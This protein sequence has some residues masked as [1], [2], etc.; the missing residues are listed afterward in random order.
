MQ[1][2]SAQGARQQE[3]G[4]IDPALRDLGSGLDGSSLANG[5]PNSPSQTRGSQQVS[6]A[7]TAPMA[8]MSTTLP[9][10]QPAVFLD[11]QLS[12][13][14][15]QPSKQTKSPILARTAPVKRQAR[16]SKK[17][18]SSGGCDQPLMPTQTD[19]ITLMQSQLEQQARL[20]AQLQQQLSSQQGAAPDQRQSISQQ[21]NDRHRR[22]DSPSYV[23]NRVGGEHG[24]YQDDEDD[25]DIV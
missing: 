8:Q 9:V 2:D 14:T 24:G 16:S 15:I 22:S 5:M 13:Q 25:E 11:P 17:S 6:Q 18:A 20:I 23:P 19:E 1:I 7:P 4:E 21:H 12:H 10:D 3:H